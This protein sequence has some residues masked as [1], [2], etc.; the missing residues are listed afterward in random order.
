M[1]IGIITKKRTSKRWSVSGLCRYALS[2]TA[3]Y[4]PQINK[5]EHNTTKTQ[6]TSFSGE[7]DIRVEELILNEVKRLSEIY[8]KTFLDGEE[9]VE[10][11][12]LG[13]DNARA[14]MDR[15][16]FPVTK[17]GNRKIVSIL[18]FVTWQMTQ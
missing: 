17:I 4:E 13:R 3:C 15:K 12:R 9:I 2:F 16:F 5:E 8:N 14:L 10:L 11:T 7:R 6:L 1:P 18:A